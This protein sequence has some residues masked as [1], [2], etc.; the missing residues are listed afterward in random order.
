MVSLLLEVDEITEVFDFGKNYYLRKVVDGLETLEGL[1]RGSTSY[2]TL[3][4]L[5]S[6]VI[7]RKL[8]NRKL[9]VV[10]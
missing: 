2:M 5:L 8:R 6:T 1:C 9:A 7:I 3:N 10:R 4:L